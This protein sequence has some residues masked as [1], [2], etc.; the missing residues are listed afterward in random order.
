MWRSCFPEGR[1]AHLPPTVTTGMS[2]HDSPAKASG[3]LGRSAQRRDHLWR[4]LHPVTRS[5]PIKATPIADESINRELGV[6]GRQGQLSCHQRHV[7][8][9]V[10][11]E[12]SLSAG[13]WLLLID[14]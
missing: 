6:A 1:R 7:D 8:H 3:A 4:L 10:L 5:L 14:Q 12:Q 11:D 2:W 9:R 13:G